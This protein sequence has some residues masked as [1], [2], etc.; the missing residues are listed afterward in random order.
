SASRSVQGF[1]AKS[2]PLVIQD[3]FGAGAGQ[4]A[5]VLKENDFIP[6]E[7]TEDCVVAW[8]ERY[9]REVPGS[10]KESFLANDPKKGPLGEVKAPKDVN[11]LILPYRGDDSEEFAPMLRQAH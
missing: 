9:Y 11:G 4:V 10:N 8:A 3:Y 2:N 6:I 5:A 1:R 7:I